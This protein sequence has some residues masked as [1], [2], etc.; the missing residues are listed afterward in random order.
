MTM[1]CHH[2]RGPRNRRWCSGCAPRMKLGRTRTARTTV[3]RFVVLFCWWA[4]RRLMSTAGRS[5]RGRTRTRA[6]AT[7]PRPDGGFPSSP[8]GC[9]RS[10]P[11]NFSKLQPTAASGCTTS[12]HRPCVLAALVLGLLAVGLP[13]PLAAEEPCGPSVSEPI[14]NPGGV[15][16]GLG[17]ASGLV[18]SGRHPGV[19][20][21]HQDSAHDASIFAVRFDA[22]G[23][24]LVIS[25]GG[26][27][28][29]LAIARERAQRQGGDL[30]Y[31]RK[32]FVL[33]LPL[34][35]AA[36]GRRTG[37]G[38]RRARLRSS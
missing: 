33:T 12:G 29:G 13:R 5:P 37:S 2:G 26:T 19:A 16:P 9:R 24:S 38:A 17:E 20:W 28:L 25:R 8:G 3:R 14:K 18:S 34:Q 31:G 10:L 30:A 32:T 21:A 4:T 1:R 27:G 36:P 35:A 15:P 11:G 22:D 23:D 6:L 7:D